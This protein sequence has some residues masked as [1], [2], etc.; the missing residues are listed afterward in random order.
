MLGL[1]VRAWGWVRSLRFDSCFLLLEGI[2][3][4]GLGVFC[5]IYHD[6]VQYILI[7]HEFISIHIKHLRQHINIIP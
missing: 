5:A 1:R 7:E 4:W 2:L 3:A 6:S